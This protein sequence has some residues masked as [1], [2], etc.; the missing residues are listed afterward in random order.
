MTYSGL[1][2]R[3][4]RHDIRSKN[5]FPHRFGNVTIN[6]AGA[7]EYK[8]LIDIIFQKMKLPLLATKLYRWFVHSNIDETIHNDVIIP[9]G[10]I[11][12]DN[13]YE[14]L[15]GLR[16]LLASEHFYDECIIGTMVKIQL[17]LF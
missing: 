12:R 6:N 16:A 4:G 2:Y 3:A 14:I 10:K 9:M 5:A 13:N 7:E 15:P 1:E 11:I 8:N 17:I